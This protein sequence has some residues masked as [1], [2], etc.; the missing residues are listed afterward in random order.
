MVSSL[1]LSEIIQSVS[2]SVSEPRMNAIL[3]GRTGMKNNAPVIASTRMDLRKNWLAKRMKG[4]KTFREWQRHLFGR[5]A[6]LFATIT[7]SKSTCWRGSEWKEYRIL[8]GKKATGTEW[9]ER[10]PIMLNINRKKVLGSNHS[11][12]RFLFPSSLSLMRTS[13]FS[14]V[15]S[16]SC[17]SAFR[18]LFVKLMWVYIYSGGTRIPA[19]VNVQKLAV[20]VLREWYAPFFSFFFICINSSSLPSI[21]NLKAADC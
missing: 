5:L 15:L 3:L 20:Y 12:L 10:K 18:L 4:I 13:R 19:N 8:E 11:P 17:L 2:P 16:I 1:S 21:D 6:I 14:Q 7:L 9:A